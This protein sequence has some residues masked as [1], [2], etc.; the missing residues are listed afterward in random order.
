MGG[1]SERE[2]VAVIRGSGSTSVAK[3]RLRMLLAALLATFLSALL[4]AG[5][6]SAV[7][8]P[9]H[10]SCV[11]V[12]SSTLFSFVGDREPKTMCQHHGRAPAQLKIVSRDLSSAA[13]TFSPVATTAPPQLSADAGALPPAAARALSERATLATPPPTGVAA[14]DGGLLFRG[15]AKTH[16]GYEDA[17]NGVAKPRGGLA[18]AA[19]HNAGDTR[20]E[21]TSWTTD[22]STAES[23]SYPGG[24]VLSVPKASVA[25]RVFGSPDLYDEFEILIR[26]P[27]SGARVG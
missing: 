1:Y 24:V 5:S 14:E 12:A 10:Q 16:P 15:V 22:R 13:T 8:S 11:G 17:L 19:E 7:A 3:V 20:S 4:P 27:V 9:A 23:F 26:G 21:F 18:S 2:R 6:A 25:N